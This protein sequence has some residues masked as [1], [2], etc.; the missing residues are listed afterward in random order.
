M[1]EAIIS[2]YANG[3]KALMGRV[4]GISPQAISTWIARN[5]FDAE[6]IY[7]KCESINPDWLLTGNGDMIIDRKKEYPIDKENTAVLLNEPAGS[8]NRK[9]IERKYEVQRIPLYNIQAIAGLIPLFT[10][11]YTQ[12]V[13]QYIEKPNAPRCDGAIHV[14]GD[15]MYPIIKAGDI[16]MY[17]EIHDIPDNIF[18][19]EMYLIGL[20]IEGDEMITVKYIQ[21]SDK[22]GCIKL[23]SQNQHHQD[24]DIEISRIRALAFVKASIRFN[25]IK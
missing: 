13:E 14:T 25:H 22:A 20:D 7:A 4:L 23:V 3:N 8:F 12:T 6:L 10:G 18:Y 24:R 21:K 17:K 15:S 11:Q 5:T 16:I 1:L 19:G 9:C 2:R